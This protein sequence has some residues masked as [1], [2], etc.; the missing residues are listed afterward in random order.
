MFDA[1]DLL[2]NLLE[3]ENDLTTQQRVRLQL[4]AIFGDKAEEAFEFMMREKPAINEIGGL[5]IPDE[6]CRTQF[7]KNQNTD[8]DGVYIIYENGHYELFNDRNSTENV[9]YVGVIFGGKRIAVALEDLGGTG[10]EFQFLKDG[11]KAP[12]TS[13]FYTDT[14]GINAFEWFNGE[15]ST[16]HI[17]EDYK[18]EI[19]LDLLKEKEYIPSMGEF[20]LLMMVAS[21]LNRALAYVGGKPIE[22]WYWSST[23]GSQNYA[24]VVGFSNGGVGIYT[25]GVKYGSYSVRAVAA[26]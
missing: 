6:N 24:W 5:A 21:V 2:D 8:A 12:E 16:R 23:E 25:T 26:F 11:F 19:P 17:K 13:K 7:V 1:E 15:D 3:K 4:Y 18:T 22:G 10:K 14:L 20:G 9:K